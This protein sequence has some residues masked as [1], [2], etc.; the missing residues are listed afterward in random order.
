MGDCLYL[1]I[2]TRSGADL[3][4]TGVY[5]YAED[6]KFD[7][8]MLAWAWNDE[9][10]QTSTDP[11]EMRGI[12][13]D[14]LERH[15]RGEDFKV[16]AHN[17]GFERVC[18]S[19][20]IGMPVGSYIPPEV[21]EDT[22]VL[23]AWSGLPLS[24]K[25]L[26]K[27]MGGE[28]KDEAGSALIRFFCTPKKDG[29]FRTPED[30]IERWQSFVDYCAQDVIAM[31]DIHKKLKPSVTDFEVETW[32][33]SERTNDRGVR[34]D[35]DMALA[36]VA[37]SESNKQTALDRMA[38][39]TDLPN[40]NSVSQLGGWL[41]EQGLEVDSLNKAAVEEFLEQDDLPADVREVLELRQHVALSSSAKYQAELDSVSSDGRIRGTL[42][43]YGA[44]TG[45]FS[46]R[47]LQLQN[48]PSEGIADDDTEVEARI[49]DL[50]LGLST[51]QVDLKR[52]IRSSLVGPF[53]VVDYSQI[54][55][56]VLAHLA[57]EQWAIDAFFSGEDL[58]SSAASRMYDV[59]YEEAKAKYRKQGKIATLALGYGGSKGA[60]KAFGAPGTDEDLMDIVYKWRNANES[61]VQYWRDLMTAFKEGGSVG[62]V[63]FFKDGSNRHLVL[64]SGRSI[65]YR[66]CTKRT[67]V[68]PFTGKEQE[69]IYRKDYR[70]KGFPVKVWGGIICENLV[71][72]YA[73]DVL[74][75]ALVRLDREG[76]RT[77]GSVHDE[78]IVEASTE[79]ELHRIGEIMTTAP[80]WMS[81]FPLAAEGAGPI[82][83]YRKADG[84]WGFANYKE[85]WRL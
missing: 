20:Y 25:E 48:L 37:M 44:H 73:R 49:I 54:E 29:T 77:V 62:D 82:A 59:S 38:E 11:D 75:D 35:V 85:K 80:N 3:K 36:A 32:H 10:M 22:M 24:L 14:I 46:G 6:E 67:E 39:L 51:P 16:I 12:I 47:R 74:T 21:F 84:T 66:N 45:R 70:K 64:P 30:D 76:F 52:M 72:A 50:K 79:S 42:M 9:P 57:G 78:V 83:R 69:V 13:R 28:L 33:V 17:T 23:A 5:R 65:V 1:D 56:R 19:S 61:I 31:R 2:E 55:A 15:D 60:L 40:P 71:Q 53:A 8:L 26:A 34:I 43:Y 68:N 58:Y 41:R 81:N 7:I 18:F 4:K 63:S 27:A